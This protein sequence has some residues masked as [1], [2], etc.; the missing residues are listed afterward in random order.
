MADGGHGNLIPGAGGSITTRRANTY[1]HF[2]FVVWAML[3]PDIDSI[4]VRRVKNALRVSTETAQKMRNHWRNLTASRFYHD[5]V[6]DIVSVQQRIFGRGRLD[7]R[8][9]AVVRA[10]R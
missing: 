9:G 4:T 10:E 3:Q 7:A 5:S 2:Q 6:P 1:T 8:G